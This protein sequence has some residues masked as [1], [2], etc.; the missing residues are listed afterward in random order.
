MLFATG[1]LDDVRGLS[2][3]AKVAGM[4]AAAVV[5]YGSGISIDVFRVPF[6]DLVFLSAEWSVLLTVLWV[7]GMANAVNLIDGLDGLGRRASWPSRRQHS[8]C[9]GCA[10]PTRA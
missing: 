3:P 6:W 7:V 4:A 1:F 5:L 10:S 2:P 8:C 9:T